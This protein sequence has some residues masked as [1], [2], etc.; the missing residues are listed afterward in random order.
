[1]CGG[2]VGVKSC[3]SFALCVWCEFHMTLGPGREDTKADSMSGVSGGGVSN[4]S[5]GGKQ[6]LKMLKSRSGSVFQFASG[7]VQC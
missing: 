5:I 1:M 2:K 4:R 7:C 3:R 6:C